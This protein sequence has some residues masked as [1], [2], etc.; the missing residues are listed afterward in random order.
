MLTLHTPFHSLPPFSVGPDEPTARRQALE[1]ELQETPARDR[2]PAP[3]SFSTF[4]RVLAC[5]L[6]AS[7]AY[8]TAST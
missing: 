2:G 4:R 6:C 8:R 5:W 7:L 1:P 3:P